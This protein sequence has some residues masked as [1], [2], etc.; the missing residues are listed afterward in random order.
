MLKVSVRR[1]C[2]RQEV[3]CHANSSESEDFVL[4]AF[5]L[6]DKL[7]ILALH[8]PAYIGITV[9]SHYNASVDN[10]KTIYITVNR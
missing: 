5:S 4:A 8:F 1:V 9:Y 3:F 10:P 7:Q 6:N 2:K